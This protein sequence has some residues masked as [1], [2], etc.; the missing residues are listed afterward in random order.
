MPWGFPLNRAD[1]RRYSPPVRRTFL[2]LGLLAH[3]AFGAE[4]ARVPG[5]SATT[6]A[7]QDRDR[8][9][10]DWQ[11]RHAE[12]L[13]RHR[14]FKPDVVIFGDSIIHYWG[15]E[16]VAPKAWAPQAWSNCFAGLKVSN[17]GFGWDRTENVLWRI[18]HGEL[19]GIKPKVIIIKI[20]TNNTAVDDAPADIAAGIEAVCA[21]AH[22]KQPGAKI[23]LLGILPRHDEKPPRPSI[24][25]KVNALLASRFTEAPWLTF[26]DFGSGFRGPDGIP[27]PKLYSDGV[28]INAAG[29]DILGAKIREQLLALIPQTLWASD[30]RI[31]F[32]GDSIAYDGRW[33][34]LVESTL[35]AT[36]PFADAE[37]VNLGLPSETV[38]G[39][40]E[41]GH[42]GGQFPRPCLHERLERVL[43]AF[44]PTLVLACYGMNDGIYLPAAPAR[45]KAFQEGIRNLKFAAEQHGARIIF[46]TPPLY[47]AG[48]SSDDP[49]RYDAVL[50]GYANWLVSQRAAGWQVVDIRPALKQA[51]AQTLAATAAFVYAADGVHP[52]DDGHRF[53][54]EAVCQGLWPL[55]NL[56]GSPRFAMGPA[57]AILKQRQDLLKLAWLSQTRHLRPGIPAGLPLDQARDKAVPLLADY[58]AAI[59]SPGGG[60]PAKVSQ[61]SGYERLD[62]EVDGRAALLVRPKDPAPSK[63]W[64]WRTEFFGHEPQGDIALLGRG[65]HV[66]Y[67]DVQNMYGAPVALKHMEQFHACLTRVYG[68]SPKPVLEGFSRGGLFAFNWAALHP[69]LVAGLY[70]DA[71]VCDFKSWPGGKG[72]GPGSPADWQNLLKVYGF[73]EQQA[74]AYDKNP[75]DNLA[76]L[77]KAHIPILAIIGDADE[78]VPVS[79]NSNLVESRYQA[80]G[81]QIRV[82][83]KPGGKH[84]PHSLPDPAPIVDFAVLAAK[85]P[86][87]TGES[88]PR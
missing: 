47:R 87:G 32:L 23:L 54:A 5:V 73:A 48:K 85:G 18:E 62:F 21:A 70:V 26:R 17:L 22:H 86:G 79:E 45:F 19:D 41:E 57:L 67:I 13:A 2:C 75:V 65:F 40:S 58:R 78:V 35:R 33:P 82:I 49:N 3:L 16:P 14:E 46:I 80:L 68:L 10:Y 56:P 51:V 24:T 71:P 43:T 52:G 63:P 30:A 42:A 66:A 77:A 72:V 64:I 28:H 6:P 59:A 7:T 34:A 27:D 1:T 55:L 83:R 9:T 60:P 36:P 15:G 38:S 88:S 20:G 11:K 39:L 12:V 50:D 29:Y 84:H 25:E 69:D 81:G 37:I 53:I 8:A 61:W 76:P 4:P 44:K 74:L 31:A